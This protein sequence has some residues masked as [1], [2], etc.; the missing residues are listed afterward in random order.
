MGVIIDGKTNA[1]KESAYAPGIQD[2]GDLSGGALVIVAVAEPAAADFT[3]P[4]TIAAPVDARWAVASFAAVVGYNVTAADG[5][6]RCRVYVDAQDP[7]NLILDVTTAG[8]VADFDSA[9]ISG[10]WIPAVFALLSDGLPHDF[11]FFLWKDGMGVGTT[12]DAL[13]LFAGVGSGDGAGAF[14]SLT[15][16]GARGLAT[17]SGL[18]GVRFGG[19]GASQ[20]NIVCSPAG[21][22]VTGGD[23]LTVGPTAGD[24]PLSLVE[25]GGN[26]FN[27]RPVHLLGSLGVVTEAIAAD[28]ATFVSYLRIIWNDI[29]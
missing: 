21:T 16:T 1:I 14:E 29:E 17:I 8:A 18:F 25:G 10:V 3:V 12:L 23:I 9:T 27:A 5:N 6:F 22:G 4:I 24:Q 26:W 7:A 20:T 13:E 11:L 19:G 15:F 2:S 28:T